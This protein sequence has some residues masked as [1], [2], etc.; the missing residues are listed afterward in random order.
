VILKLRNIHH[1]LLLSAPF[2]AYNLC[3]NSRQ[4][5]G[6]APTEDRIYDKMLAVL[7]CR[8]PREVAI[9]EYVKVKVKLSL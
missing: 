7:S 5:E 1:Y 2:E 9:D 8:T 3:S 4:V 6:D